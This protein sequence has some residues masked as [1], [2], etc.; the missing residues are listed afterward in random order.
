M[1]HL[2][3]AVLLPLLAQALGPRQAAIADGDAI[4]TAD[5][6]SSEPKV[7]YSAGQ[8]AVCVEGFLQVPLVAVNK[9]IFYDGPKDNYELTALLA[10]YMRV[11]SNVTSQLVGGDIY[12]V[13][14]YSIFSR[15]CLP[16]NE[17]ATEKQVDSVQFLTHG[18]FTDATY[19]DFAEDFSYID[20]AAEKGYA[21]F[22]Y[23]RLGSG[24][25]E[26]P[27]PLS[28]VQLGVQTALAHKL[29]ASL[30]EGKI[31]GI[32]FQHVIGIGHSIG[33][34]IT[35]SI[36]ANHPDDF[37]ALILSGHSASSDTTNLAMVSTSQQ[38]ASTK[39]SRF[40]RLHNGYVTT[41][42]VSQSMQFAFYHYP[43]VSKRSKFK[44]MMTIYCWSRLY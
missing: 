36:S 20:A 9:K 35:Q 27:H 5:G 19:W 3:L 41:A 26:H 30:K 11:N 17:R 22:S 39:A 43:T 18:A 14:T 21:T 4:F 28:V 8:Q 23:D 7:T 31:A 2:F 44:Q 33:S 40:K 12:V 1:L 32:L 34:A 10:D 37:S 25:S 29:V 24:R 6:F 38:I 15:L 13:D 42:P 16:A